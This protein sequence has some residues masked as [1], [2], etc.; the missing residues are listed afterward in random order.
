MLCGLIRWAHAP[1]QSFQLK[2]DKLGRCLRAPPL[3]LS[4]KVR[5]FRLV[6][7]YLLL[8]QS[9]YGQ[10]QSLLVLPSTMMT[11]RSSPCGHTQA[12]IYILYIPML[13]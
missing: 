8:S 7:V 4:L 12:S 3:F 10:G 6:Y 13:T 2:F 1:F 9:P 11:H 5:V